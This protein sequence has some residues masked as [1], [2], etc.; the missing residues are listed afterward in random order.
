M[1]AATAA[2]AALPAVALEKFPARTIQ[3]VVPYPPGGSNDLVARAVGRKLAELAGQPVVVEN[4]PGA[5][6][7]IGTDL[8]AKARPD[9]HTLAF[10]SSSYATNAAVQSKLP[11]DPVRGLAAVALMGRVPFVI[12]VSNALPVR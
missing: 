9:G 11:F 12:A 8:V 2:F 6:G 10:V 3:I 4:R 5:G 7:S 1:L